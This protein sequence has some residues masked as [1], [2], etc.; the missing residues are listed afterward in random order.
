METFNSS[1]ASE[2]YQAAQMADDVDSDSTSMAPG[3]PED[4]TR[5]VNMAEPTEFSSRQRRPLPHHPLIGEEGM[6]SV[7]GEAGQQMADGNIGTLT[8]P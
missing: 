1:I 7:C 8:A 3:N 6:G 2:A 5:T 4:T